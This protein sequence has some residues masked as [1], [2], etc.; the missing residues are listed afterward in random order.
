[1]GAVG[2]GAV[3]MLELGGSCVCVW[4]GGALCMA[5]VSRALAVYLGPGHQL[6]SLTKWLM[7]PQPP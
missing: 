3:C 6:A 1:M 5:F 4:G 7:W 2:R